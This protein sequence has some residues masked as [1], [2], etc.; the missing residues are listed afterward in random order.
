MPI[1]IESFRGAYEG[2]DTNKLS[3]TALTISDEAKTQVNVGRGKPLALSDLQQLPGGG[4]SRIMNNVYLRGQLLS[5]IRDTLMTL[6]EDGSKKEFKSDLTKNFFESA[7][8]KLFG[9]LDANT[10]TGKLEFGVQTASADLDAKTVNDLLSDLDTIMAVERTRQFSE[11]PELKD[12]LDLVAKLMS[13]DPAALGKAVGISSASKV[14][15]AAISDLKMVDGCLQFTI[16]PRE[17]LAEPKTAFVRADGTISLYKTDADE[18]TAV[19]KENLESFKFGAS[20]L[21]VKSIPQ[22]IHKDVSRLLTFAKEGYAPFDDVLH[23]KYG[24]NY[25]GELTACLKAALVMMLPKAC[26]KIPLIQSDGKSITLKTWWKALGLK[27]EVPAENASGSD[28]GCALLKAVYNR[29][30]E[31]FSRI[32]GLSEDEKLYLEKSVPEEDTKKLKGQ[33]GTFLMSDLPYEATIKCMQSREGGKINL[34][35]E[36]LNFTVQTQDT[37]TDKNLDDV[38]ALANETT[39]SRY[40]GSSFEYRAMNGDTVT[41][42][43]GKN[44]FKEINKAAVNRLH[45]KENFSMKQ[46]GLM[47]HS[48]N[49]SMQTLP[50]A[51][52]YMANEYNCKIKVEAVGDPNAPKMKVTYAIPLIKDG[53]FN[54]FLV[55]NK[56]VVQEIV[57]EQNGE[58]MCASVQ[59]EKTSDTPGRIADETI[60]PTVEWAAGTFTGTPLLN[61]KPI[62]IDPKYCE[63]DLKVRQRDL[64]NR[65]NSENGHQETF[66]QTAVD[67]YRDYSKRL[68]GNEEK[69]FQTNPNVW[70]EQDVAGGKRVAYMVN[71]RQVP[72]QPKNENDTAPIEKF[73]NLSLANELKDA[74]EIDISTIL[75]NVA[76]P[77]EGTYIPLETDSEAYNEVCKQVAT[78]NNLPLENVKQSFVEGSGVG[79]IVTQTG[80][81]KVVTK[82]QLE[83][84]RIAMYFCCHTTWAG[85]DDLL[86]YEQNVE[87]FGGM[88][89]YDKNGENSIRTVNV[90]RSPDG[91]GYDVFVKQRHASIVGLY[92]K[93]ED[94]PNY[95][96]KVKQY[97]DPL[98]PGEMTMSYAYHVELDRSSE[99]WTPKITYKEP[100]TVRV[101]LPDPIT[102]GEFKSNTMKFAKN[103]LDKIVRNASDQDDGFKTWWNNL[104]AKGVEEELAKA[105]DSVAT[106]ATELQSPISVRQLVVQLGLQY[107]AAT[108]A[109]ISDQTVRTNVTD[110]FQK[111]PTITVKNGGDEVNETI[112]YNDKFK[113]LRWKPK[114]TIDDDEEVEYDDLSHYLGRLGKFDEI[115]RLQLA[116]GRLFYGGIDCL[117]KGCSALEEQNGPK[118]NVTVELKIDTNTKDFNLVV[119]EGEVKA[120]LSAKVDFTRMFGNNNSFVQPLNK[121]TSIV[122]IEKI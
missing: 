55:T 7:E 26:E 30:K 9:A 58:A 98:H 90:V 61:V 8:K 101:N 2:I 67:V 108:I 65:F 115:N 23:S 93:V 121:K 113:G 99:Q 87:Q 17:K 70:P 66:G 6:N 13:A 49:N 33:F 59:I 48:V 85:P 36:E 76:K 74:P 78:K 111:I 18:E 40:M 119:S 47:I 117:R 29:T 82:Y 68:P 42:N 19:L 44:K 25:N 32:M 28:I 3:Q 79:L 118:Q 73:S 56:D 12:H 60:W 104:G 94:N 21:I 50:T 69:I 35:Q 14:R 72:G 11:S 5:S 62:E 52:G 114:I 39:D 100:L 15:Q 122:K 81:A 22:T 24:G 91:S 38:E 77:A 34:S 103:N 51:F 97:F 64:A 4:D 45:E 110:L 102:F 86:L 37:I 89:I 20:N 112:V 95:D 107:R 46:I 1:S 57:I 53:G 88:P 71:G 10:K 63:D 31:D 84:Q 120:T 105:V 16:T 80:Q 92:D 75:P 43:L 109:P 41:I 54:R 83:L 106:A 96:G 116:L 27:G